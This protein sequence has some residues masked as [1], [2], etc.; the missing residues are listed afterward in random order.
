MSTAVAYLST[1]KPYQ[2]DI[3]ASCP[4]PPRR[5]ASESFSH[6][7][8]MCPTFPSLDARNNGFFLA[9]P[10][11]SSP[12]LMDHDDQDDEELLSFHI[13]ML[14]P[15]ASFQVRRNVPISTLQP[16]P[17]KSAADVDMKMS[18]ALPNTFQLVRNNTGMRRSSSFHSPAA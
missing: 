11:S 13:P 5:A 16:R 2:M 8:N 6:V 4:P 15:R 14:K 10:S 7:D 9:A 12:V 17:A 3:T 18:S 1:P